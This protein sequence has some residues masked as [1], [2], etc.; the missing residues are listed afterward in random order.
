MKHKPT[1]ES[2]MITIEATF[3]LIM[4]VAAISCIISLI[5]IFTLHNRI[6]YALTQTAQQYSS[7]MYIYDGLGL[8]DVVDK[9]D[10]Y[11]DEA[12][13]QINSSAQDLTNAGKSATEFLGSLTDVVEAL[14]AIGGVSGKSEFSFESIR[15][16]VDQFKT[17]KSDIN[18]SYDSSLSLIQSIRD[19][20]YSLLLTLFY[21]ATDELENTIKSIISENLTYCIMEQYISSF[22]ADGKIINDSADK[23]LKAHG[24]VNGYKGLNF[25]GTNIFEPI[26]T[27]KKGNK[28]VSDS[29]RSLNVLQVD[30]VVSYDVKLDFPLVPLKENTVTIVQRA[31]TAAWTGHK[32]S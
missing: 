6:Q 16:L 26:K 1:D 14:G 19:N 12:T 23:Y 5:N 8:K 29:D 11:S 10:S 18:T 28:Y 4:F 21:L 7:Y 22:S 27:A 2:G 15:S 17:V 24:V 20:P 13:N 31:T 30:I 9:F 32:N 3:S 25:K